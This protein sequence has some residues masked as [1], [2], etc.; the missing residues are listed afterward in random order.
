MRI[1]AGRRYGVPRCGGVVGIASLLQVS[2]SA[3]SG[4]LPRL[5]EVWVGV[6][7]LCRVSGGV[8]GIDRG[9][10]GQAPALRML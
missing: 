6:V 1:E 10:G 9:G 8:V 2:P 7:L 4:H 5:R 3:P